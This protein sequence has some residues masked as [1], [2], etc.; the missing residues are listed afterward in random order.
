[1]SMRLS[2]DTIAAKRDSIPLLRFCKTQLPAIAWGWAGL[3]LL[4]FDWSWSN[5]QILEITR[6]AAVQ[7]QV[8]HAEAKKFSGSWLSSLASSWEI[9]QW[10]NCDLPRGEITKGLWNK[11][12]QFHWIRCY[13]HQ[14]WHWNRTQSLRPKSIWLGT[15]GIK[16][17]WR[18][19]IIHNNKSKNNS[20]SFNMFLSSYLSSFHPL[21]LK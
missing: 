3:L 6:L 5:I 10:I 7:S 9:D 19:Q 20:Q 13:T 21:E 4:S 1:V 14:S 15:H 2:T 8:K 17:S 12:I 18:I 11:D 16:K